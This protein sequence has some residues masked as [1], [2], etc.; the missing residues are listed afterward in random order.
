MT[1]FKFTPGDKVVVERMPM[2]PGFEGT[3]ISSHGR[4]VVV[5]Y[6][7]FK[8]AVTESFDVRK[9]CWKHGSDVYH[10]VTD[11]LA[12]DPRREASWG[13]NH[14]MDARPLLADIDV[15]KAGRVYE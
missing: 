14:L 13:P 5:E 3:V 8:E 7:P 1:D 15:E 12:E 6:T 2:D 10:R 11:W 4:T 9:I